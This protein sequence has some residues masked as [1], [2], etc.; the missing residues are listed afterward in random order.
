M[1]QKTDYA[2]QPQPF[3]IRRS[4]IYA[5]V[6][7][8]ENAVEIVDGERTYWSADAY[9]LQMLDSETLEARISGNIGTW[10]AYAKQIDYAITAE[11]ARKTRDGLLAETDMYMRD[12]YPVS[13]EYKQ[14]IAAYSQLLRDVPEQADFPYS[15]EWPAKPAAPAKASQELTRVKVDN[16]VTAFDALIGGDAV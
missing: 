7:L 4:G 10:L 14:Q 9:V 8:T 15:I 3:E 13:V 12:D 6:T 16:L 11:Q 2:E 1:R 5:F